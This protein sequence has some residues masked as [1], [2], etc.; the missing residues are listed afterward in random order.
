M[1]EVKTDKNG[2]KYYN[3]FKENVQFR[4]IGFHSWKMGGASWRVLFCDPYTTDKKLRWMTFDIPAISDDEVEMHQKKVITYRASAQD[5]D[6]GI[7][8]IREIITRLGYPT[9]NDFPDNLWKVRSMGS[10]EAQKKMLEEIFKGDPRDKSLWNVMGSMKVTPSGSVYYKI[11]KFLKADKIQDAAWTEAW[12]YQPEGAAQ[13]KEPSKD[14]VEQYRANAQA[15][16]AEV[17][18]VL[19]EASIKNESSTQDEMMQASAAFDE[20]PP[21]QLR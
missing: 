13:N 5:R 14:E 4:S 11:E 17:R 21:P 10:E 2:N 12:G 3:F 15:Q 1:S 8:K 6:T 18:K 16:E 7:D 20:A 19:H 9:P